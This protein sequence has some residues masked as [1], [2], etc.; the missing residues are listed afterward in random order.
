MSSA[1]LLEKASFG[2]SWSPRT[3]CALTLSLV[4]LSGGLLGALAMDFVVHSRQRP[5]AFDTPMGKAA[6]FERMK[7][8]LNL[9]PAQSE[10]MESILND[11]WQYYRTVLSDGKQR[12]E[13]V[14]TPEQKVKFERLLQDP[15]K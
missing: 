6:Y 5:P 11:F 2:K 3:V 7:R 9:T 8:E 10:Q 1:N 14:L 15:K 4:F 12:I 13:Q